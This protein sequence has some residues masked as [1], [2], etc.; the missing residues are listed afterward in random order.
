MEQLLLS[1]LEDYQLT[2]QE[3]STDV[4]ALAHSPPRFMFTVRN[5]SSS[6]GQLESTTLVHRLGAAP[7]MLLPAGDSDDELL[8]STHRMH[9]ASQAGVYF[10]PPSAS[11]AADSNDAPVDVPSERFVS[12]S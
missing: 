11:G 4:Q 9:F 5:H 2:A 3:S 6:A 7:A 1:K 10:P 8:G 12:T